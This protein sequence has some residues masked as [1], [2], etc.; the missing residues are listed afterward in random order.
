MSESSPDEAAPRQLAPTVRG[1]YPSPPAPPIAS[2]P[3]S[4]TGTRT[5]GA[6]DGQLA[7][8]LANMHL[9]KLRA[10]RP[11][12]KAKAKAR[13]S[14]KKMQRRKYLA[15]SDAADSEAWRCYHTTG[16]SARCSHDRCQAGVRFC[17]MHYM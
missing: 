6:D 12:I 2:V 4:P 16:E 17:K 13:A 1:G 7:D 14:E 3:V 15:L 9:D 8:Q 5:S 11:A 10:Q